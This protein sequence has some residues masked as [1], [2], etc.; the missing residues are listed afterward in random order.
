LVARSIGRRRKRRRADPPINMNLHSFKD[1]NFGAMSANGNMLF[2]SASRPPSLTL[3]TTPSSRIIA[4]PQSAFAQNRSTSAFT[5]QNIVI[6]EEE[7]ED[8]YFM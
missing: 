5:K 4:P 8:I 7:L 6:K 1:E 2:P 3:A